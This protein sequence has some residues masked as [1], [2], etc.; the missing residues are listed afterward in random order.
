[1]VRLE[2]LISPQLLFSLYDETGCFNE[3]SLAHFH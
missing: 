2:P 3:I 1:V